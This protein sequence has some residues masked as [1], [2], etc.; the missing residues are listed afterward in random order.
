MG[1]A[2]KNMSERGIRLLGGFCVARVPRSS[3]PLTTV[4][5]TEVLE[6][7]YTRIMRETALSIDPERDIPEEERTKENIEYL[8]KVINLKEVNEFAL[9][10]GI[11][12]SSLLPQPATVSP[13][14][15]KGPKPLR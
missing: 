7:C 14:F 10:C 8:N 6:S 11:I 5:Y 1:N 15:G 4:F 2:I 12:I 3:Q 13:Q 9:R